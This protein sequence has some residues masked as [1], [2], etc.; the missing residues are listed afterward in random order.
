M[1]IK[2]NYLNILN[3]AKEL[4][5]VDTPMILAVSKKQPEAKIREAIESGIYKFGENQIKEGLEKFIPIKNEGLKFELHHIGPV[6]TGTLKKLLGT[7]DY[8][9]GI[10]SENSLK[11]LSKQA[12]TRK[13]K[14]SFFLQANL[15]LE[16]TKSGLELK[17]LLQLLKNIIIFENDFCK[18]SGLM[19]M[20]PS[21][22]DPIQTRKV[23]KQLKSIKDEYCPNALLS[24]GM[25]GDYRIA[26]EE[27]SNI[28]RIGTAIFGGRKHGIHK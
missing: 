16:D 10:G 3:A 6:Q 23:F 22:E 8:T 4:R 7:F 5:P 20:G 19:T 18:F 24:M 26:I 14:I 27:G 1:P 2:D 28:I 17:E 25:S 15:T 13:T 12:N 11:E 9:H 21:N